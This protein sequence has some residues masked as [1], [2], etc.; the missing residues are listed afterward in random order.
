MK[1]KTSIDTLVRSAKQTARW[2]RIGSLLL[3]LLAILAIL[4]SLLAPKILT[5]FL[6]DESTYGEITLTNWQL[7]GLLIIT[8]SQL[9]LWILALESTR[10]SFLAIVVDQTTTG[11]RSIARAANYV[12]IGLIWSIVAQ[13]PFSVITTWGF[14]EGERLLTIGL[15]WTQISMLLVALLISF[16]SRLLVLGAALWQDYKEIV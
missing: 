10:S 11:L 6:V 4:L 15:G 12:W 13:M 5:A 3:S 8:L 9:L 14:P 16:Y 1:H 2:L 7:G